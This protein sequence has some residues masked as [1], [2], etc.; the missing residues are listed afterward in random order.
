MNYK[1]HLLVGFISFCILTGFLIKHNPN[2]LNSENI[3]IGFFLCMVGSLAPDIDH[4]NSKIYKSSM[5][6]SILI[7][8]FIAISTNNLQIAFIIALILLIIVH[9]LSKLKHRGITHNGFGVIIVLIG[10]YAV[11][12]YFNFNSP[13][14]LTLF[15]ITGYLSHIAADYLGLKY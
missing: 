1:G 7:G 6:V 9:S 10:L 3:L 14:I 4:P 11:L 2:Y 8:I 12:L 5:M 13:I 15:G